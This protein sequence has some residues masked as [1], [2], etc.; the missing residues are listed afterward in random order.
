MGEFVTF[1]QFLNEKKSPYKPET[2]EK[3]KK[4]WE[5][6]EKIPFGIEASLKAQGMIPRADGSYKVSPEYE[7]EGVKPKE[8]LLSKIKRQIGPK[9]EKPKSHAEEVEQRIHKEEKERSKP[10]KDE[11]ITKHKDFRQRGPVKNP[12]DEGH[13]GNVGK[14]KTQKSSKVLPTFKETRKKRTKKSYNPKAVVSENLLIEGII[15]TFD[16]FKI[17]DEKLHS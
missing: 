2:L 9:S 8:G 4:K 11:I 16:E 14:I 3:Y 5:K 10:K 15:P 6:G 12:D 7:K 1:D 17:I 13:E